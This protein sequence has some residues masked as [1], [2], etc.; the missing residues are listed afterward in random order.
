MFYVLPMPRKKNDGS[1]KTRGGRRQAGEGGRSRK[2]GSRSRRGEKIDE[3][4][5]REAFKR[6]VRQPRLAFYSPVAS[7]ILNYWKSAIPRF[8]ISE[9]LAKLVERELARAWPKLYE[10][11]VKRLKSSSGR[12]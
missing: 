9:F 10:R 3:K 4:L 12:G 7:C 5:F 2:S 8:S 6:A 1:E 11:T